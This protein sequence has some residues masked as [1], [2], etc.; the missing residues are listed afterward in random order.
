MNEENSTIEL[1]INGNSVL[2]SEIPEDYLQIY[3]TAFFGI[4]RKHP[5]EQDDFF[6]KIDD[7]RFYNTALN[8]NEMLTIYND[9]VSGQPI[10]GSRK[11]VI[12]DEGTESNGL[13][14]VNDEGKIRASI[15]K[16]KFS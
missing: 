5:L 10:V 1:F 13:L 7:L 9:D 15:G 16:W 14:L 2:S 6:G 12:F 8:E 11:Q 3:L 4:S